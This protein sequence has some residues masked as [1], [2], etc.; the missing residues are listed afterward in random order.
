MTNRS[1]AHP[2]TRITR[3]IALY[4]DH[5]DRIVH[6]GH[7]VY[8]VPGCSG[9]VYTVDLAVFG[10]EESCSCPDHARHKAPCKH[11]FAATVA[12][13]KARAKARRLQAD[14]TAARVSRSSLAGLAASL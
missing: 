12:R 3:G 1:L 10:G 7:G 5:A 11:V 14:R 8:T 6:E 13:S 2:T 4:R 9:G